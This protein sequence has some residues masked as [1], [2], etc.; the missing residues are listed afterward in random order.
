MEEM[1]KWAKN[2][3]DN[4]KTLYLLKTMRNEAKKQ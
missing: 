2:I 3:G 4:K 1:M